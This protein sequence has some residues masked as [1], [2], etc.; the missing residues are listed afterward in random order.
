[1]YLNLAFDRLKIIKIFKLQILKLEIFLD[2]FKMA[3]WTI[4]KY[5]TKVQR[6]PGSR[7]HAFSRPR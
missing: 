1:M 7:F 2:L 4:E 6:V 5:K 3:K